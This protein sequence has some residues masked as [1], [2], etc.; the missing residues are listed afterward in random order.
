VAILP[1]PI[2]NKR[3][4]YFHVVMGKE[5]A[6]LQRKAR[7]KAVEYWGKEELKGKEIHHRNG[8]KTDNRKENLAILT[9]KEH[10]RRDKELYK[11]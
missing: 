3:N 4:F 10:R 5:S 6:K 9:R 1:E 11:K 7:A 2:S 8:I